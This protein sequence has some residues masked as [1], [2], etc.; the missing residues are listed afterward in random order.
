MCW[1]YHMPSGQHGGAERG[2]TTLLEVSFG[3]TLNPQHLRHW[4]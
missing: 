3:L 1:L 4:S 2:N